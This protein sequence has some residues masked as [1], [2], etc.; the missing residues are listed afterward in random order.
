MLQAKIDSVDML[1]CD[2]FSQGIVYIQYDITFSCEYT[3]H[4]LFRLNMNEMGKKL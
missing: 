1:F 2:F 3:A 4:H